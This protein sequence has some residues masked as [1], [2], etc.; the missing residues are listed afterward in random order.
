VPLIERYGP[1][2]SMTDVRMMLAADC[3]RAIVNKITD[4][5]DLIYQD[6]LSK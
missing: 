1:N 3:P 5:C 6:L 4:L 2:Q